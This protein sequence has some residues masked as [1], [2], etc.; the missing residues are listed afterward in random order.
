VTVNA[1]ATLET[2]NS[3]RMNTTGGK[4]V[5]NGGT[6]LGTNPG[7]AGT[8]IGSSIGLKG[9]EVSGSGA[10]G[11][12][13]HDGMPDNKI[14]IFFGIISGTGGTTTN[15]GAGTLIKIGPDQFGIGGSNQGGGVN[16]QSL[17]TF[18]KLVVVQG[19][20]RGRGVII[21]SQFQLDERVFGA[22]PL[23]VLP[24]AITLDGG[25][26]GVNMNT[27][28]H[29]NRG[30]TIGPNGGYFDHGAGAGLNIPGPLSG[31]GTLAIGN[32]T[33]TAT[34]NPTFTLSN[35]NNVNTFTGGITGVRGLLQLNESLTAAFLNDGSTI[36]QPSNNATINVATGKTITVGVNDG[37]GT[38]S[39]PIGGGGNLTKV[40]TGTQS[41][42]GTP[43]YTGDTRIQ[44]GTLSIATA[45]LADGADIYLSSGST[46]NLSFAGTDM[47]RSLYFDNVQQS[48][49]SWGAAGSGAQFTSNLFSGTGLLNATVDVPEPASF[50]LAWFGLTWLAL[51]R[52]RQ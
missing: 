34:T 2:N 37:S 51:G 27:T 46:F 21:N 49:G 42:T 26:T 20:V 4:V 14:T 16:S 29:P 39:R 11:Y 48:A 6:L 41:L 30:I 8:L 19:G 32:P 12:D 50:V 18:A 22:V 38:W 45:Y 40:G 47:I 17:S 23:S 3:Q 5:L 31:S 44:A 10:V 52:R 33:S 9:L 1:G 15:G 25:G 28:L 7:T 13:D 43:G 36:E 35:A 24:D